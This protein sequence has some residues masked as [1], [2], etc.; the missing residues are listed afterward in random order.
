MK[1]K[2]KKSA[3]MMRNENQTIKDIVSKVNKDFA[4]FGMMQSQHANATVLNARNQFLD[5]VDQA[6]ADA[7][8]NEDNFEPETD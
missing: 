4:R 6:I 5:Q 2:V 8:L 3:D 7:N 1:T